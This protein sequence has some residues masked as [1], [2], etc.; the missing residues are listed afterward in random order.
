M[1]APAPLSKDE[2]ERLALRMGLEKP[3]RE[4]PDAVHR[5][6]SRL[7]DYSTTLPDG[8]TATSEPS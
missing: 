2:I 1:N 5:A 3:L 4:F 6:A 7:A 8:W